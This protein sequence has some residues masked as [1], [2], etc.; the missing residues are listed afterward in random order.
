MN[1]SAPPSDRKVRIRMY[2]HGFGD[3]FLLSF[4]DG[5]HMLIDCGVL[6][7]DFSHLRKAVEDVIATTAGHIDLLVATHEHWDHISGFTQARDLFEKL[8][9]GNVWLAWTEDPKD[10]QAQQLHQRFDRQ[11]GALRVIANSQENGAEQV[12]TLLQFF[13]D[14]FAFSEQTHDAMNYV[15]AR[16]GSTGHYCRPGELLTVPSIPSGRFYVLGPPKDKLL[17]KSA[18]TA[19]ETYELALATEFVDPSDRDQ[20]DSDYPFDESYKLSPT[21]LPR[22]SKD[23]FQLYEHEDDDWRRID[24]DWLGSAT[25]LALQMDSAT[26][27][28]SVALAIELV[29][30][31]DVLLFPGDAQVG[32][33]ESW[34]ELKWDSVTANDLLT[35]TVFYKAGHHG[36]HNGTLKENGLERMTSPKLTVAIPTDEKFALTRNPKGTWRMP[37]KALYAAICEKARTVTRSDQPPQESALYIDH[38]I[39]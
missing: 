23:I 10:S 31:G 4:T 38:F 11:R 21:D 25:E 30:T 28:T 8:T 24:N 29:G 13:G 3:C 27:N 33:W 15:K 19:G 22:S 37:A 32:N 34:Q 14:P 12:Q 1:V 36:S 35:R 17:R 2:C 5:G 9:F 16:M 20:S 26:N 7:S 39:V 18:P 6:N